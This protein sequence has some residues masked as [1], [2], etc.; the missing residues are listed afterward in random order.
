MCKECFDKKEFARPCQECGLRP[1]K[2]SAPVYVKTCTKCYL[3][4]KKMTHDA[5]PWCPHD[6]MKHFQLNK[7]KEAPGCRT[8]M[9]DR[10]LIKIVQHAQMV[11]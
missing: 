11:S 9:I 10:G 2:A 3:E 5:C 7:R 4:K 6:P 8:C 1:V